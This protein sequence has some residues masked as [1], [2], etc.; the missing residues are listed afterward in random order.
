MVCNAELV[1]DLVD[2]RRVPGSPV[3]ARPP[4]VMPV[5]LFGSSVPLFGASVP[6]FGSSVPLLVEAIHRDLW[7]DGLTTAAAPDEPAMG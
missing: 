7:A 6:L 2:P 5:P 3:R 1:E 4:S